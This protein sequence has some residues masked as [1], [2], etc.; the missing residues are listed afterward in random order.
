MKK[1][2]NIRK[3]TKALKKLI[4]VGCMITMVVSGINAN[5]E[6]ILPDGYMCPGSILIGVGNQ[7]EDKYE[8][9]T[10]TPVNTDYVEV[11]S[12]YQIDVAR[13]VGEL[14]AKIQVSQSVL[15]TTKTTTFS[16][17]DTTSQGYEKYLFSFIE[18]A[19]GRTN[20][21]L[22]RINYE[23]EKIARTTDN[24]QNMIAVNAY[25]KLQDVYDLINDD[26][27]L[28][29]QRNEFEPTEGYIVTEEQ[30]RSGYEQYDLFLGDY[31]A[32]KANSTTNG[33]EKFKDIL[34][35]KTSL[36]ILK[37][38]TESSF[39]TVESVRNS[40]ADLLEAYESNPSLIVATTEPVATVEPV[41]TN[42]A[43][44]TTP[45]PTIPVTGVPEIQPTAGIAT[46]EPTI[47][48]TKVP[49]IQPTAGIATPEPTIPVTEVPKVP[50][51]GPTAVVQ[52]SPIVV[53]VA[54]SEPTVTPI[55]G[56]T[57]TPAVNIESTPVI[58]TT[59][60]LDEI[61][62]KVDFYSVTIGAGESV[63]TN[64]SVKINN[65][66]EEIT[67]TVDDESIATISSKG[68]IKGIS[69]GSTQVTMRFGKYS[70]T[71]NVIV[72]LEPTRVSFNK[73]M[74]K[75]VT[76]TISKGKRKKVGIWFYKGTYSNKITLKTSNRKIATVT[77]KGVITAKKKG[78]CKITASTYN[79]KTCYAIIKVK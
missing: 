56:P 8:S 9:I 19:Y 47:P 52:S 41:A 69:V 26:I 33:A 49:E 35:Y 42:I 71:V 20:R 46:P 61:D 11:K 63:K 27:W 76:Y 79:G 12:K 55:L 65:N 5:A 37:S 24:A 72:K 39:Q 74:A 23:L 28:F 50:T 38:A 45:E 32:A 16:N 2:I 25:E 68:V 53:I 44:V 48:V 1:M 66:V 6:I 75:K 30:I 22:Y 60:K 40:I 67:Y 78:T 31:Y 29:E 17:T 77:S 34:K 18:E 57:A 13:T 15:N 3:T 54:T 21:G 43:D 7:I 14:T 70:R 51:V 58:T 59:P 62:F 10:G 64:A 73:N 4:A 36:G